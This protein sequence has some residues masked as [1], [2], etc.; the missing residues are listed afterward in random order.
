ML[1]LQGDPRGVHPRRP[2]RCHRGALRGSAPRHVPA[3]AGGGLGGEDVSTCSRAL[4]LGLQ[5]VG[6]CGRMRLKPD[7]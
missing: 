2:D 7:R 5:R 6:R 4:G 3:A 1:S